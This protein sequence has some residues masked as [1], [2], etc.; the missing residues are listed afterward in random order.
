MSDEAPG[1][2]VAPS[3]RLLPPGCSDHAGERWGTRR[4]QPWQERWGAPRDEQVD[5]KEQKLI[6]KPRRLN[7]ANVTATLALFLAVGGAT[8]FAAQHLSKNSVGAKQL[9]RNA[10]SA[11]KIK[12]S[13]VT[14][15]KVKAGAI[16]G[17]KI[18]DGSIGVSDLNLAQMPFSHVVARMR[19]SANLETTG[20]VKLFPLSPNTY[21]QAGDEI[22]TYWGTVSVTVDPSCTGPRFISAEVLVDPAN[23]VAHSAAEVV[24]GGGVQDAGLGNQVIELSPSGSDLIGASGGRFEPGAAKAHTLFLALEGRCSGGGSGIRATSA[25]VD[26]V[27]TH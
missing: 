1:L 9:K 17:E 18:G 24:A 4:A 2:R 19:G 8:A 22:D 7:Y 11:A 27:G 10:V 15:A 25:G 16:N 26:V 23:P 5:R 3:A 21:T 12:N 20:G 6:H 13:A 14:S